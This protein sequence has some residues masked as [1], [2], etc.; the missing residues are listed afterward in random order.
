[1]FG[2]FNRS[3][4]TES[5][6]AE[7]DV[8]ALYSQFFAFG[9]SAY[10]WQVSPAILAAS[11]SVPDGAGALLTEARR[12]AP[13]QP[14]L[15][16]L[17][18]LH[19][20]RNSDRRARA[21]RLRRGRSGA[22]RRGWRGPMGTGARCRGRARPVAAHHGR[23]RIADLARGPGCSARRVRGDHDRPGLD[24]PGSGDTGSARARACGATCSIS[25]TAAVAM[26]ARCPG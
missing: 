1:M 24:A 18:P 8:G 16:R 21:A 17:H 3:G 2:L 20:G 13:R 6:A 11:L 7:V 15:E 5:R 25:A 12:L 10:N 4:K 23:R 14:D 19:D 26:R 22:R 9:A